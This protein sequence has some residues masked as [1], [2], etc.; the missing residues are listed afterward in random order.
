MINT[1]RFFISLLF[2]TIALSTHTPSQAQKADYLAY[3]KQAA[4]AG[5]EA[6]PGVIERW[7]SNVDP[8][9]LWGY[10]STAHPIYLA[11]ALGFL[12]QETGEQHYAERAAQLLAEYGDLRTAYP[13]DYYKTR[14]E[15][16]NGVPSLANFFFLPPY[17]RSYL[18]IRNSDVIDDV[19]RQKIETDL[20][21]S[22]DFQ[23]TFPEWGAHNRALLRAEG[24]YYGYLAM[25]DHPNAAKWKQMAEV[26]ARDNLTQ[27]E[28]EDASGYQAIWLTALFSYVDISG[29]ADFFFSQPIVKYYAE[30]F[31]RM[32]TPAGTIPAFGDSNWDP[33]WDRF[34]AVFE[35]LANELD[36]PELKWIADQLFTR[37]V[38][39]NRYGVGAAS[40]LALAFEWADES[41]VP[42][43]P[44]SGSQEILEDMVGKKVIFRDGWDPTSTYLLLNYRDEGDG[45][46]VHRDYLRNSLTV[47]EEKA[48]HGQADEND[49][50]LLMAGGSVLLHSSG[51]RSGLPSGP[52]GQFRADYYHNKLVV[53]KDKRDPTNQSVQEFIRNAGAY[54][55][56][57]TKKVDFLVFEDVEMSRTRL[58]DDKLGYTW[59]RTITY[60]KEDD[61]FVVID[62]VRSDITDYFTYTNLW[63]T[64]QIHAQGP[65]YFD[66]SIDSI[67]NVSL[68]DDK[69]LLIQFLEQNAKQ[70]GVYD[71]RRHFQDEQAIYQTQ[72]SHY[73]AGDYEVFVTVLMPHDAG[74]PLQSML[75][76]FSLVKPASYPDGVAVQIDRGDETA[77][78]CLKIN[79][80]SE[81]ARE[82]I[83]PRYT[84]EDGRIAF[85]DIETDAHFLYATIKGDQFKFAASQFMNIYFKG[86]PVMEA[87]PNTHGLQPDGSPPKV[88][89]TKW[90]AWES[91]F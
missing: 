18:R 20:A 77:Y 19:M 7:R 23:F 4:E 54:R 91:G 42:E 55:P 67:R 26:I 29:D 25:P 1:A 36:D 90:R 3:V 89:F 13:D 87:L 60:L 76:R 43:K 61:A 62:A 63:H 15:Y 21:Y 2:F 51:Y 80:E 58:I 37:A 48:H 10:N 64:R 82:N 41:I 24:W 28:I 35:R 75:D 57:R 6:Y 8:S 83:R 72:S 22:L 53:R 71:E 44:S 5:W 79:L 32:F 9:V 30:Y 11:D 33:S 73:L 85:G 47:E 84:W 46:L 69:R 78:L 17:S 86:E 16:E 68:P 40:H 34:I 12:Y 45:G 38:A 88:G 66:T 14:V 74:A 59:D 27:W 49:I 56:V 50:P 65:G 39:N 31:K 70:E 52:F 81:L